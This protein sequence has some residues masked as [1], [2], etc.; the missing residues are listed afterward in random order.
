[1]DK[2]KSIITGDAQSKPA[3]TATGAFT[4]QDSPDAHTT[5]GTS[6]DDP[7][8]PGTSKIEGMVDKG[9]LFSS[10]IPIPDMSHIEAEQS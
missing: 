1:M 2:V 5:Q 9:M 10:E 8:V 3:K 6:V 7:N 4:T